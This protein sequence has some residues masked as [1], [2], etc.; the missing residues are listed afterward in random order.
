MTIPFEGV[1]LADQKSWYSELQDLGYTDLWSAEVNG[2]DAFVPLAVAAEHA[3]RMNLG[4]AVV[5]VYTRGPG[6]LAMSAAAIAELAPGRFSIGIGTSSDVIV[7]RW[8]GIAFDEPFKRVRDTIRFLRAAFRGEKVDGEFE[9]FATKGFRLGRPLPVPPDILVAALRPGMLKLA[10]A[11]ADGAIT[12]WLSASDVKQVAATMGEGKTLAAR[13]FVIPSEDAAMARMV[14]KIAISQYLN[15]AVYAAFHEWL[16]RGDDLK[17]MWEKWKEGD[18]SG[19]TE[20]IPDHVVD[21]LIVH[22]SAGQCKEHIMRYAENGIDVPIMM[23][24]PTGYDMQKAVRE[25]AP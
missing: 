20:S 6:L 1:S 23:L 4:T 22:G 2:L 19:A 25:L 13:I 12:N 24:I 18:R 16:G 7:E 3:P 17:P 15:V 10:S 5:P 21:D 8:N 9:T 11:E 14:G